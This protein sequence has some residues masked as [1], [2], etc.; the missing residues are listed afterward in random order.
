MV[1]N[2]DGLSSIK[3]YDLFLR[4]S[5]KVTFLKACTQWTYKDQDVG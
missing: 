2:G 1:T 3:S 4:W 5:R